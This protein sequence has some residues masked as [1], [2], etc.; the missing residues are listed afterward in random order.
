MKRFY[1]LALAGF[2]F[3]S[4]K[5]QSDSTAMRANLTA[6]ANKMGQ[7]FID[8]NYR[9][10][11]SYVHPELI[12]MIGGPDKMIAMFEKPL[13]EGVT[14]R[15][16]WYEEPLQLIGTPKDIEAVLPEN[17]E[18]NTPKGKLVARSYT[19]AISKDK[20]KTWHF[21]STS[22]KTLDQMRV[23]LPS[24][25]PKLVLPETAAPKLTK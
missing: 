6:A 9:E 16:V 1:A 15:K 5:A 20:G 25:S 8:K 23:V 14:F 10:Y 3:I 11:L 19:I 4:A 17:I 12:K 21:V 24:L 2:L 18:L 22:G 13:G 7:L